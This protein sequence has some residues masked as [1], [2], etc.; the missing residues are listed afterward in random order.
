MSSL[1]SI[2]NFVGSDSILNNQPRVIDPTHPEQRQG[3]AENNNQQLS[4]DK[5]AAKAY[6]AA[7]ANNDPKQIQ[8]AGETIWNSPKGQEYQARIAALSAQMK[9]Q[10]EQQQEQERQVAQIQS[11]VRRM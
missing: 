10:E 8:E 7:I 1:H 9:L 11:P 4:I 2:D 6:L 3:L 5:D